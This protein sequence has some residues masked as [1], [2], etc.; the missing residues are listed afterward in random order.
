MG[1]AAWGSG[2]LLQAPAKAI[3]WQDNIQPSVAHIANLAGR[4]RRATLSM[5]KKLE[6]TAERIF[7][8]PGVRY[9]VLILL[10]ASLSSI[11]ARA[12]PITWPGAGAA[13]ARSSGSSGGICWI[14]LL[15]CCYQVE[16]QAECAQ[17]TYSAG[18]LHFRAECVCLFQ[19]KSVRRVAGMYRLSVVKNA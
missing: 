2:A 16:W 7:G 17:W 3:S 15:C 4:R 9:M 10:R 18:A 14:S 1:G 5:P 8:V 11:S 6:V 13:G 19:V 12:L